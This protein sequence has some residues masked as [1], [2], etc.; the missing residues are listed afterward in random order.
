MEVST[1]LRM[2][3]KEQTEGRRLKLNPLNTGLCQT[4]YTEFR[5]PC[6]IL[7]LLILSNY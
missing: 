4:F 6:S 1:Y 7:V 3:L 5:V 2:L